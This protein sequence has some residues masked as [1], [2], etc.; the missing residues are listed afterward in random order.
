ME[1]QKVG[2]KKVELLV[3]LRKR[4]RYAAI[5]LIVDTHAKTWDQAVPV[6][7]Q[8]FSRLR[9]GGYSP[10]VAVRLVSTPCTQPKSSFA[11]DP[12]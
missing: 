5:D 12:L 4:R 2:Q 7:P 6:Q 8:T 9:V 10:R 3:H 11:G 1:L